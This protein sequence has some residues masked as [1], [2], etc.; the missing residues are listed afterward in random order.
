[1]VGYVGDD[2]NAGIVRHEFAVR[3]VNTEFVVTAPERPTNTYGK[4]RAGGF[5]IPTQEILRTDTPSPTFISGAVE[6]QIMANIEKLA[7]RSTPCGGRP[8]SSVATAR[9]LETVVAAP[10]DKLLRWAIRGLRAH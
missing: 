5:N 2:V 7:L 9:V 4:L 3:S 6:E 10:E 8:V 1:M